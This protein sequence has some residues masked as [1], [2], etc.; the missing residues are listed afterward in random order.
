M[1]LQHMEAVGLCGAGQAGFLL[2]SG[3]TSLGGSIPVNVSGGA[4]GVG[5]LF[6]CSGAQKLAE[7]CTQ[8]RDEAGAR[9]VKDAEVGL[10]QS[11]RGVPA[12]TS[13]VAILAN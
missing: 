1:E 11:W 10:V 7:T 3:E 12:T 6:E 4:Q 13:C 2:D 5:H 9:Q 8:L